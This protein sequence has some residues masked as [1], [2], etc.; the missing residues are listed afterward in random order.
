MSNIELNI[1]RWDPATLEQRRTHGHAPKILIIGKTGTGKTTLVQDLLFYF[2][3]KIHSGVVICPTEQS[4]VDYRLMFPETFIH[5]AWNSDLIAEFIRMQ[6]QIRKTDPNF[7]QILMLDDIM[8]DKNAIL[9]DESTRF[10]FMNGR[11][12]NISMIITMQY[13]MDLPPDLRNNI[14]FVIALRDNI[15]ANREKLWRNFFG[16]IPTADSFHQIFQRCTVGYNCIVL[17]NTSRSA[18][19]E[20]C[21]F[22]YAADARDDNARIIQ[23]SPRHGPDTYNIVFDDG[24]AVDGVNKALIKPLDSGAGAPVQPQTEFRPGENVKVKFKRTW[25]TLPPRKRRCFHSSMWN[26]HSTRFNPH[27]DEGPGESNTL[28]TTASGGAGNGGGAGAGASAS[29]GGGAGQ[30]DFQQQFRRLKRGERAN[31]SVKMI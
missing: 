23:R 15:H 27:Y 10:I 16:V 1:R 30:M 25:L 8:Y 6:K 24:S 17:D 12:N 29:P 20:D 7:H 28:A 31:L 18:N 5:E 4:L 26:F 19:L 2:A 21:I 11:N 13:C 9:K 14:D 22:Y 3:R